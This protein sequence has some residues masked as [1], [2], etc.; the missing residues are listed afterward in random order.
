LGLTSAP[1]AGTDAGLPSNPTDPNDFH[2]GSGCSMTWTVHA[3]Y[4]ATAE[5]FA[6][7]SSIPDNPEPMVINGC[8]VAGTAMAGGQLAPVQYSDLTTG[9]VSS[10]PPSGDP[11]AT[12]Y[13]YVTQTSQA[14]C[15]SAAANACGAD[16]RRVILAAVLNSQST[17]IGSNYP[18]YSTTV[19]SNPAPTN[20]PGTA[21]GLR[22]LGVIS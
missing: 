10:T 8:T 2:T 16:V 20:Q 18:T 1:A 11:Y 17:D 15:S 6:S 5:S 19:F 13:T 21:S 4:N 3:N 22:V 7:G 9:I 14:G 12:I